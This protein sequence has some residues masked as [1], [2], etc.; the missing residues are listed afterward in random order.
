LPTNEEF[1]RLVRLANKGDSDA[2]E[3]LQRIVRSCEE[4]WGPYADL[5]G[6]VEATLI[7]MIAGENVVLREALRTKMGELKNSLRGKTDNP[8]D[9]LLVDQIMILW[10]DS[11]YTHM[12]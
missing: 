7:G 8:V 9:A 12:A 6:H 3:E 1:Q 5:N 10:L 4:I 11:R 2:A